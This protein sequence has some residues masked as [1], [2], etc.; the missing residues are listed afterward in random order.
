MSRRVDKRGAKKENLGMRESESACAFLRE[1]AGV[2]ACV[3]E[4]VR[5]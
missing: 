3:C 4:C 5:V 1:R 2:S